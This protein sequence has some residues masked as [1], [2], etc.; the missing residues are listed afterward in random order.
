MAAS[1]APAREKRTIDRMLAVCFVLLARLQVPDWRGVYSIYLCLQRGWLEYRRRSSILDGLD[2]QK[3]PPDK[4]G[5]TLL[6]LAS[7]LG[8]TALLAC[9]GSPLA[10]PIRLPSGQKTVLGQGCTY[11]HHGQALTPPY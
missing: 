2:P 8:S 5:S 3:A 4:S 7:G 9:P 1:S 11:A 6:C 10:S